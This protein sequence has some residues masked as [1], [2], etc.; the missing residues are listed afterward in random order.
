LT[1]RGRVQSFRTFDLKNPTICR[2]GVEQIVDAVNDFKGHAEAYALAA[3][4]SIEN[5]TH[6]KVAAKAIELVNRKPVV[7]PVC[8]SVAI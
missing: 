8:R 5:Q 6:E 1:L 2:F 7:V 4:L 3:S